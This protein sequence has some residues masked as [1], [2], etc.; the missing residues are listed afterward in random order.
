[1]RR[2][3]GESVYSGDGLTM[4]TSSIFEILRTNMLT[5][6][7]AGPSEVKMYETEQ[8]LS[9]EQLQTHAST[10]SAQI[11]IAIPNNRQSLKSESCYTV[12][13]FMEALAS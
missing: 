4:V 3:R 2:G 1:M 6:T 7:T 5:R 9:S 12:F 8:N 11:S 10:L 13:V